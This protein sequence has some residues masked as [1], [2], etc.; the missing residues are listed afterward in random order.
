MALEQSNKGSPRQAS[1][2]RKSDSDDH[3]PQSTV[4][5]KLFYFFKG[6]HFLLGLGLTRLFL[7]RTLFD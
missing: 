3:L 6:M 5:P 4:S 2:I 7:G 1:K